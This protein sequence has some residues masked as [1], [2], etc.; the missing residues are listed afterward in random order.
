VAASLPAHRLRGDDVDAVAY[1]VRLRPG[2][3]IDLPADSRPDSATLEYVVAG[4]YAVRSDDPLVV[5]RDLAAGTG[6]TAEEVPAEQEAAVA[7]GRQCSTGA[8]TRP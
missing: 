1:T 7:Q 5:L 8:A 2:G 6:G 4:T 3:H